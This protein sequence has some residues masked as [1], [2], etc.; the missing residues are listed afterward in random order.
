MNLALWDQ[1]PYQCLARSL[2]ASKPLSE[3][4]F[5]RKT[6]YLNLPIVQGTAM[7]VMEVFLLKHE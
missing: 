7:S 5:F 4:E 3:E 2:L 1:V 6:G